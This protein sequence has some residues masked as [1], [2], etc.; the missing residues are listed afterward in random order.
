LA[1]FSVH[2]EFYSYCILFSGVERKLKNGLQLEVLPCG[3]LIDKYSKQKFIKQ[4]LGKYFEEII[5]V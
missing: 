1:D 3:H 5:A 4:V 2:S